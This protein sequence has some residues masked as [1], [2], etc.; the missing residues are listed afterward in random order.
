MTPRL[1]GPLR[2]EG[3]PVSDERML[4]VKLPSGGFG[5]IKR[6]SSPGRFCPANALDFQ[7]SLSEV[8]VRSIWP[9]SHTGGPGLRSRLPIA[10]CM[11][12]E[13]PGCL[14]ADGRAVLADTAGCG[15]PV[16]TREGE[17]ACRYLL[18]A[19]TLTARAFGAP[20]ASPALCLRRNFIPLAEMLMIALCAFGIDHAAGEF[21][22]RRFQMIDDTLL[23]RSSCSS[24]RP[25]PP[26]RLR[27]PNEGYPTPSG[28]IA[29][30]EV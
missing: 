6:E 14:P 3:F 27:I 16:H 13:G 22:T 9:A 5:L 24:L 21:K 20:E 4:L 10:D 8:R 23:R 30:V 12:G 28:T 17:I 25:L 2:A 1:T 15:P 19:A 11:A 18:R 7:S 29:I 26:H